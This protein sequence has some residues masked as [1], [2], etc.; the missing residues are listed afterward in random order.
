MNGRAFHATRS[1]GCRAPPRSTI[2]RSGDLLAIDRCILDVVA[3]EIVSIVGPSGCGK[4]TLLWSMSGPAS[5][6]RPARSCS[7]ASR[8][9]ARTPR[10]AWSSRRPTCCPGAISTP[11]SSFPFE[12][13]GTQARP[14]AGSTSCC[15][16][17]GLDGFGGKLPARAF[18][19]HAAARRDRAGAVVQA[20]GAADGRAVRRAR[21]LH[22]R[23]DEPAGRGDLA[24]DQD[25]HRASSP[26]RS[27]RR[28]SSPTAS[29]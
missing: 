25:D 26:T 15:N 21:R 11:T 22:P 18:R 27:T 3:G 23:G 2:R 20:V 8:S 9:P 14:G 29:S 17:V 7:T 16:R 28:S 12:I 5:P 13:K 1:S 6:D 19:R 10:S 24:R 4:T